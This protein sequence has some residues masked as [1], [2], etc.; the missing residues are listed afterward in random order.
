M[1]LNIPTSVPVFI[2][3]AESD[4]PSNGKFT[5]AKLKIFYLGE[6]SDHRVFTSAF[7]DK[8]LESLGKNLVVVRITICI[9]RAYNLI[10]MQVS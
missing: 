4:A 6:T 1:T 8:L 7:S 2:Q 5:K 3:T 9:T 10:D